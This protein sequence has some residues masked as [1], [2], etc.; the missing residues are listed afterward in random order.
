MLHRNIASGD[1]GQMDSRCR[2]PDDLREGNPAEASNA[3][4]RAGSNDPVV[5]V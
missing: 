4:P 1:S 2:P 5:D 3:E